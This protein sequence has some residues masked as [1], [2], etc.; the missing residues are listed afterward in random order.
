M[1][2]H[3]SFRSLGG[4]RAAGLINSKLLKNSR[5]SHD[6]MHVSDWLPTLLAAAGYDVTKETNDLDG[7]N[8]WETLNDPNVTSPREDIL[9]NIDEEL[10]N[11][12]A[13]RV[14]DWKLVNQS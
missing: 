13:L 2:Q 8:L 5:V 6:M 12:A 7:M 4:V 3:F 14:G 9:I 11:N 10:Y 1:K